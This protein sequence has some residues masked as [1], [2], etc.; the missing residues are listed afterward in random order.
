MT[1]RIK[2]KY[3]EWVP[4]VYNI[5]IYILSEKHGDTLVAGPTQ[6]TTDALSYMRKIFPHI[7]WEDH[8]QVGT[9]IGN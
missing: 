1:D 7:A 8:L 4:G 6:Y 2:V 3:E 5:W 9:E